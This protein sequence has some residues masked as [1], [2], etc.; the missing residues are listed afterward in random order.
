MN[1][2]KESIRSEIIN[3]NSIDHIWENTST[4]LIRGDRCKS[5][6]ANQVH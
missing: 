5:G 4:E 3:N 2:Q 6:N 1:L